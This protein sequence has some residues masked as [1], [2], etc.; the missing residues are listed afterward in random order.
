[1]RI[2]YN[3]TEGGRERRNVHVAA[4]PSETY[5]IICADEPVMTSIVLEQAGAQ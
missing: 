1:V 5:T 2:V 4:K 3:W